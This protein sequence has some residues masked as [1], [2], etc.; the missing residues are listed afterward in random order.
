M[1]PSFPRDATVQSILSAVK[2]LAAVDTLN[3][4][5]VQ[6]VQTSA[7]ARTQISRVHRL[8]A[9]ALGGIVPA[10]A[11][12]RDHS[13]LAFH[14]KFL[15]RADELKWHSSV[16]QNTPF[17]SQAL[18]EQTRIDSARER[19][20]RYCPDCAKE[21]VHRHGCAHW[22]VGHQLGAVF[23][24]PTHHAR[25]LG[26]CA[27]CRAPFR[28]TFRLYLPGDP[29][30]VCGCKEGT[31]ADVLVPEAY[32][33]YLELCRRA[34]SDQAPELR[35]IA[36]KAI[37]SKLN[38]QMNTVGRAASLGNLF[39][40]SWGVSSST[41]LKQQFEARVDQGT[42]ERL[43]ESGVAAAPNQIVAAVVSFAVCNLPSSLLAE[44]LQESDD[45]LNFPICATPPSLHD[46]LTH[47]ASLSGFP[48]ESARA[49]AEGAYDAMH[50]DKATKSSTDRFL[51][52]LP[53]DLRLRIRAA[54]DKSQH[55]KSAMRPKGALGNLEKARAAAMAILSKGDRRRCS[56]PQF[57]YLWLKKHDEPWLDLHFPARWGSPTDSM[58]EH[59]RSTA[60][61][62]KAQGVVTR[63]A[64]MV[65]SMSTYKWLTRRD[66]KWFDENFPSCRN[67]PRRTK[68]HDDP[69]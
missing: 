59:R 1:I 17:A 27:G 38:A 52:G 32:W 69:H 34:L 49:L 51:A 3:E 44:A 31:S 25:L 13:S 8:S 4:E 67:R 20:L 36:R 18:S 16:A 53:E 23:H 62:L 30:R 47:H 46:L 6:T 15:T 45:T 24:C 57:A 60:L 58:R 14:G 35:P 5:M 56:I 39:F 22:R 43:F 26:L 10:D 42:V 63:S 7:F 11:L 28:S 66:W 19:E 37:V 29:C 55:D 64:L 65:A 41:G 54:R 33:A 48:V 9:L 40:K 61:Q 68:P 2:R 12:A 50:S 21:D